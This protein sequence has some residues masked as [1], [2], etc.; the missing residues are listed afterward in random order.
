M[1]RTARPF[2]VAACLVGLTIATAAQVAGPQVDVPQSQSPNGALDTQLV[3]TGLY[4]ISGGG[5][6]T[7]LRFSADGLILVDGK[8]SGNYRAVMSQVRR[9]SK[10]SDLPVRF[11]ILTDRQDDRVGNVGQF[12]KAGVRII[13]QENTIRHL[14]S[15]TG[16]ENAGPPAVTFDRTY[17]LHFG[18]IDV[19]LMNFGAAHTNGDAVVYFPNLRVVAVGDL[20]G[21]SPEPDYSAGGS[22]VNW[23]IALREILKLDFDVVVASNGPAVSR[24]ELQSFK[25]RLDTLI[26]RGSDLV[27]RGVPKEQM[28]RELKT[29]DLGWQLN[30]GRVQLD[31]FYAE[32]SRHSAQISAGR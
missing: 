26:S 16:Q 17:M 22:L 25:T 18:G 19:Q 15:L 24:A 29:D 27:K 13:A 12:A 28:M 31:A 2:T 9:V 21:S 8:Q 1:W 7:L 5:S 3:K 6:N 32:L 23:G 10:I 14:P 20:L 4:L 30:F 11:L